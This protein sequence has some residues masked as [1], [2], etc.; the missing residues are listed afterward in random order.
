VVEL[1]ADERHIVFEQ[2][3]TALDAACPPC[4]VAATRIQSRYR[5]TLV[6]RGG[7]RRLVDFPMR[8]LVGAVGS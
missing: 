2:A 8:A 3:T 1:Q 5:R 6:Q 4:G 7:S